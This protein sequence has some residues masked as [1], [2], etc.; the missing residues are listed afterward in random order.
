MMNNFFR[1]YIYLF[2]SFY[3]VIGATTEWLTQPST[4]YL[5]FLSTK[6]QVLTETHQFDDFYASLKP[7]S[8]HQYLLRA[9]VDLTSVNTAIPIRDERMKKLFFKVLQFP[10]ASLRATLPPPTSL[11]EAGSV[12][13][14][15]LPAQLSLHGKIRPV[16]LSLSITRL[17]N[18]TLVVN[19]RKPLLINTAD[20]GLKNG[21]NALKAIAAL[22]HISTV[23]PVTFQVT[24]TT[25]T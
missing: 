6:Q 22:S 7:V 15:E 3:S 12:I 20:Y 10:N 23:I 24:L 19:T 8:E 16:V 25:A 9:S 4:S 17:N 11:V 1:Y 5:H 14:Y 18:D 21:V 13:N 2:I